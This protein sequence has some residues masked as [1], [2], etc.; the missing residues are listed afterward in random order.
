LQQVT[1]EAAAMPIWQTC[2]HALPAIWLQEVTVS[3]CEAGA[4][5]DRNPDEMPRLRNVQPIR[6]LGDRHLSKPFIN[7]PFNC[8][9][10]T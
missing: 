5:V 1:G 9:V 8:R 6:G 10:M 2:R 7:R 4:L 3:L